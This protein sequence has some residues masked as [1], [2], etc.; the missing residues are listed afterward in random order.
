MKSGAESSPGFKNSSRGTS[1]AEAPF[2]PLKNADI[3]SRAQGEPCQTEEMP[4]KPERIVLQDQGK[5]NAGLSP[6]RPHAFSGQK[7]ILPGFDINLQKGGLPLG[8]AEFGRFAGDMAMQTPLRTQL[9][10]VRFFR[11]N[12]DPAVAD[13]PIMDFRSRIGIQQEKTQGTK[14]HPLGPIET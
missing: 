11:L 12:T 4:K 14:A 6:R 3:P 7:N 5:S 1:G 9:K 10:D 8:A 13:H 2:L